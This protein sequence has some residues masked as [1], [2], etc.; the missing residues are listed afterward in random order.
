MYNNDMWDYIFKTKKENE[1]KQ[2]ILKEFFNSTAQK[3]AILKA[4]RES[5]KDQRD[6]VEKYRKLKLDKKCR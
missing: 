2:I 3:K 5:A 1:A 4:A 6:L